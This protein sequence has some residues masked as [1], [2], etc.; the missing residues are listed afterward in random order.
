[1]IKVKNLTGTSDNNP[2][3]GYAS[4]RAWWEAK[5]K[6]KFGICS[7]SDCRSSAQVGAHVQKVGSDNRWYI[8]PLCSPCNTGKKNQE[9]YVREE[10]LVAVN[11]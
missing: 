5:T 10:D 3:I 11:S 2:P 1:M 4:W 9:F 6:R 7:C 8:V